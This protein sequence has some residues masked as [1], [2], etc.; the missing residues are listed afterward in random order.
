MSSATAALAEDVN[1]RD[2]DGHSEGKADRAGR[3]G[4]Q[5]LVLAEEDHTGGDRNKDPERLE[6]R[7]D[8]E[9]VETLQTGVEP[10]RSDRE[11]ERE[12]DKP[13]ESRISVE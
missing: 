7:N 10:L 3:G 6:H 13:S 5:R 8:V 9:R 1:P 12:G 11:T 4:D 2:G